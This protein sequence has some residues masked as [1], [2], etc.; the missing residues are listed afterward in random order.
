MS[1]VLDSNLWISAFIFRGR[2]L[3]MG[4]DRLVD[5]AVSQSIIDET[6]RVMNDKFHAK[7]IVLESALFIMTTSARMVEPVIQVKAVRDDPNDD[8]VVSCAIAAGAEAIITGDK[9]LLRN[10]FKQSPGRGSVEYPEGTGGSCAD[11]KRLP[12]EHWIPFVCPWSARLSRKGA[13][14]I[15]PLRYASVG[16]TRV[17]RLLFG[18]VATWMEGVRNCADR[19]SLHFA[20]L[21]SG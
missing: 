16:M 10:I 11:R 13:L 9:H 1:V 19:R 4:L 5:I 7:P 14:Q 15:P 3:E 2:P 6:L 17:E 12:P 18:R 8:H 20:A 21:R